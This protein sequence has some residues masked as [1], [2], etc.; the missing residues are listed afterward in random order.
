MSKDK[1]TDSKLRAAKPEDKEYNLGD[2]DGLYLRVKPN[3]SRL[4]VFNYYR[5]TD[6]KRANISFGPY[7]EV[8]LSIA[9]DLR[10]RGSCF[11][12]SEH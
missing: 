4:W 8:T 9:R 7:P 10:S 12:G 11:V 6:K 1:L 3:G 5:P 2:G